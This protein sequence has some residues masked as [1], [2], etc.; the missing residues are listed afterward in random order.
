MKQATMS[1]TFRQALPLD[2][3]NRDLLANVHPDDWR[4][5]EPAR[6]YNLVVVG[7]G[8][9]GLVTAAGAAGLGAK[10][11][12]V[13]RELLGGDCL[14][15]G[16]VPSKALLRAARAA[17]D[18]RAASEFG[19][20]ID[21]EVRVDFPVVMERMRRL[22]ARLSPHDS[23]SRF[24]DLG[25]DVFLG[26]GR[27][28]SPETLE[29]GGAT[30]RFSRACIATGARPVVPPIAGLSEADALTNE[31]VFTLTELPGR[32]AMLGGGPIGCELAQAFARFGSEVH[33]IE[34][35]PRIL[36][37]EHPPA[38]ERVERA[39]RADGVKIAV[40][41]KLVEVRR[42]AG[43]KLLVLEV[44]GD[45]RELEVDEILVGVG[46]AP[47]VQGLGLETAG[48]E[49][50][51]KDGVKVDD[52]LRTTQPRIYAAGDVASAYKFTHVAD[53]LARIVIRNA[54]FFGRVRA[55]DLIV[56]W[57]T[58]TDPEI[59]HVG[60]YP[61]EA[62]KRGIELDTYTVDLA[63]VDRAVLDGEEAGLFDVH[64]ARGSDRILG[65]TL[66]ARHAGESISEITLA[67]NS[68]A[69]LRTIARTI[70]P[71]PTQAEAARRAGDLCERARLTPRLKRLVTAFLAWRR[72]R[73]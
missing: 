50:D 65:A 33:L 62:E 14:S 27:F 63:D 61:S 9:A 28:T 43:N 3:H 17:A 6:R 30:L 19:V 21:G 16:C 5:P 13:E 56:P 22:R 58:Y 12:L 73:A 48:V 4:N 51:A 46:R 37:R 39:L 68:G 71:Y 57:C 26:Q 35:A 20:R 29:V 69:G 1:T 41:T 59:A 24:R 31:T 44:E 42:K 32:F 54:L 36:G 38:V 11:A 15:V 40:G 34:M 67:M 52:H 10:V 45:R 47:N 18:A 66:V 23:A 25:V 7:A 2:R 60:I 55:S 70:H 49:H 8:T 64:V 72:G 53:A